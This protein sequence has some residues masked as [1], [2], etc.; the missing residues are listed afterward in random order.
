MWYFENSFFFTHHDVLESIQVARIDSLLFFVPMVWIYHIFFHHLPTIGISVTTSL[1]IL[2]TKLLWEVVY[3][4]LLDIIFHFFFWNK[5]PEVWLLGNIVNECLVFKE[6]P[7]YFPEWH[8][9]LHFHLLC[10]G[11]YNIFM[12][13]LLIDVNL[14]DIMVLIYFL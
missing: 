14:L 8:I 12:L 2:Q 3:R 1:G 13:V 11:I 5:C 4:I 7:N 6:L 9:I 10:T